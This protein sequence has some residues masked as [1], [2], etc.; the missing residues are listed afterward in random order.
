[1]CLINWVDFGRDM[2]PPSRS[3]CRGPVVRPVVLVKNGEIKV[4]SNS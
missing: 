2:S 4:L 1:M 3:H